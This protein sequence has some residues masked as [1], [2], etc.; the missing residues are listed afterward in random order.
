[1]VLVCDCGLFYGDGLFE[2]VWVVVGVVLLWLW[3]MV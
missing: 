1:M 3:Y 2:M